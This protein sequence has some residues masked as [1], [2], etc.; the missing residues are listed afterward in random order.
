[1][2]T[3][4]S[5]QRSRPPREPP[6]LDDPNQ[7]LPPHGDCKSLAFGCRA[8]IIPGWA[9]TECRPSGSLSSCQPTPDRRDGRSLIADASISRECSRKAPVC[10]LEAKAG[11][12]PSRFPNEV[13]AYS[14]GGAC[15]GATASVVA[16]AE[17]G[18]TTREKSAFR[19]SDQRLLG[20]PPTRRFGRYA[21]TSLACFE[22]RL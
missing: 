10:A 15:T 4:Q 17:T 16:F 8:T 12:A 11:P 20:T 1:V 5:T 14:T 22:T 13:I 6:P 9:S 19:S 21:S 18:G 3:R 7:I 2:P